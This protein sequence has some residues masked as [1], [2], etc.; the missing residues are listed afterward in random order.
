[1]LRLGKKGKKSRPLFKWYDRIRMKRIIR[2]TRGGY[3]QREREKIWRDEGLIYFS[4]K[5]VWA[6]V[7]SRQSYLPTLFHA[8]VAGRA[9][10]DALIT[11]PSDRTHI[12]LCNRGRTTLLLHALAVL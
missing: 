3:Q 7:V 6:P 11:R 4:W 10:A 12:T 8:T 9:S 1:M 5:F 2:F